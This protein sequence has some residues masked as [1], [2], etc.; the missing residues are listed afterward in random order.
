MPAEGVVLAGGLMPT[1]GVVVLGGGVAAL[2]A[3]AAAGPGATAAVDTPLATPFAPL[4]IWM[5]FMLGS[6]RK[7][8]PSRRRFGSVITNALSLEISF[9]C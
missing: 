1:E 8:T 7:P 2:V 5:F 6:D 3:G 9:L 4:R